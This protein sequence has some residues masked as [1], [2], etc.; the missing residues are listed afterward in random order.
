MWIAYSDRQWESWYILCQQLESTAKKVG[1]KWSICLCSKRYWVIKF[2]S[3]DTLPWKSLSSLHK[4]YPVD[5]SVSEYFVLFGIKRNLE[6]SSYFNGR[7]TNIMTFITSENEKKTKANATAV[8]QCFSDNYVEL[9][10]RFAIPLHSKVS[11][12]IAVVLAYYNFCTRR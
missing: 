5:F 6:D 4:L 12:K 3:P 11:Y 1:L 10:T 2:I 9:L 7:E 8:S